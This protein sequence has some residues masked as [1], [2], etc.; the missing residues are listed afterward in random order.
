MM[1]HDGNINSNLNIS[2]DQIVENPAMG[3]NNV[4]ISSIMTS[5]Y[6]TLET[7]S[8]SSDLEGEFGICGGSSG[9]KKYPITEKELMER[10]R[11]NKE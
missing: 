4:G 5:I 8:L 7:W 6:P 1:D 2:E 11:I 3:K 9:E 10:R